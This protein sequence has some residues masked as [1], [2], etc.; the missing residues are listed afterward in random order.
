MALPPTEGPTQGPRFLPSELST[1]PLAGTSLPFFFVEQQIS[2]NKKEREI[3]ISGLPS[4]LQNLMRSFLKDLADCEHL[5]LELKKISSTNRS[6]AAAE[7][8]KIREELVERV[9]KLNMHYGSH[10]FDDA[11]ITAEIRSVDSNELDIHFST[12]ITLNCFINQFLYLREVKQFLHQHKLQILKEFYAEKYSGLNLELIDFD[13]KQA[14][15]ETHH[16]GRSPVTVICKHGKDEIFKIVYKPRNAALDKAV[17]DTFFQINQLPAAQ[18]SS[19]IP[20]PFYKIVNFDN[21]SLWEFVDGTDIK[22]ERSA[23]VFINSN[24]EGNR[25]EKAQKYLDRMDA[26]LTK[27]GISD[28][29]RENIK[30]KYLQAHDKDVE[31]IPIDLENWQK[32]Q[33]S[34]LGGHPKKVI[35]SSQEEQLINNFFEPIA[36][37]VSCRYLPLSTHVMAGLIGDY[38]SCEKLT[39]MLLT[40]F[41]RDKFS[42]IM[43][44]QDLQRLILI[45]ILNRDVPYF[46]ELNNVLYYGLPGEGQVLAKKRG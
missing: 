20:L 17:I 24:L 36:R 16:Q 38:R 11:Y 6:N 19:D 21:R 25:L 46:A 4:D 32:G 43:R 29:H 14:S 40:Q 8:A 7:S 22:K 31:L 13:V 3:K 27:M 15:N 9:K 37:T 33:P 18:K 34:Q 28:L 45:S 12:E 1:A 39:T 35:L 30:V 10:G 2:M 42:I 23:G 26:I 5:L 41:E 44:P